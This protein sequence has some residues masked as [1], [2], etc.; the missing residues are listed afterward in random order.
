M[1]RSSASVALAV[2][3]HD[4]R[5]FSLIEAVVATV[6]AVVAVIGMA[7]SFGMGRALI[8]RYEIGRVALGTVQRR[9]EFYAMRPSVEIASP[10]SDS[11]AF[12]Y[13]G[14]NIGWE[15]WN[16]VWVDDPFDGLGAGDTSNG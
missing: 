5:G 6:I 15:S 2:E 16:V 1:L 11:V 14:K 13:D 3:P 9:M 10:Q 4:Q 8:S 12:V 7:H